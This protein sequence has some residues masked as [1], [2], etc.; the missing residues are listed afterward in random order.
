[1]VFQ[2]R[3]K[4][5]DKVYFVKKAYDYLMLSK[6]VDEY[7]DT[8]LEGIVTDV[9]MVIMEEDSI[10]KHKASLILA[11]ENGKKFC[12]REDLVFDDIEK[13]LDAA[14]RIADKTLSTRSISDVLQLVQPYDYNKHAYEDRAKSNV[15]IGDEVDN[16]KVIE[17]VALLSTGDVRYVIKKD[18]KKF[19]TGMQQLDVFGR[20]MV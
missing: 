13:A 2:S 9:R 11:L 1:M 6:N 16:G 3:Y 12:C 4:I 14:E 7:M 17:A 18:V 5:G 8:V 10:I 20:A 15:E 19:A